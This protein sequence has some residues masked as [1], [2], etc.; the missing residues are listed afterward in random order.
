[1]TSEQRLDRLERIAKLMVRAGLNAR[2]KIRKHDEKV[3]MLL[4][5][6]IRLEDAQIRT[7]AAFERLAESQAHT[8]RKLNALIEIVRRNSENSSN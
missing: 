8:D 3:V 7:E 2:R 1:M 6:H 4:D 5:A